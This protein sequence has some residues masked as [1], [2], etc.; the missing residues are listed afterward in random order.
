MCVCMVL[1]VELDAINIFGFK[2]LFENS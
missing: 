1:C 2:T